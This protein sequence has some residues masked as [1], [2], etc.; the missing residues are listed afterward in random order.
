[1]LALDLSCRV[2]RDA[3]DLP[4][5]LS[6]PNLLA[7]YCETWACHQGIACIVC[8]W[9]PR[10]KSQAICSRSNARQRVQ[11]RT[12]LR[13]DPLSQSSMLPLAL[14]SAHNDRSA[15]PVRPHTGRTLPHASLHGRG[16]CLRRKSAKIHGVV[17]KT[18]G[19]RALSMM[20]PL[21]LGSDEVIDPVAW[22]MGGKPI[23]STVGWAAGKRSAARSDLSLGGVR[24]SR[25]MGR[26]AS[27]FFAFW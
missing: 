18:A 25:I 1:M 10:N 23:Q 12:T 7:T 14:P 17:A 24:V 9:L 19:G 27:Q 6:K 3:L 21:R 15:S 2:S 22:V 20:V 26:D 16:W 11:R 4:S 5:S 13:V 8:R